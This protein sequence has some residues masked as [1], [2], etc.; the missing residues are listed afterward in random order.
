MNDL[1]F[2]GNYLRSVLDA[3]PSFVFVV[4]EN[5]KILDVNKAAS[6]LIGQNPELIINHIGGDILHCLHSMESN[7]C[8]TSQFCKDCV[9]RNSVEAANSGK[10]IHRKKHKMEIQKNDKK[11][12]IHF[13]VSASP[14]QYNE[15]SLVL[16]IL[17]DITD[18]AELQKIIPI[19]ANCKKIRNDNNY[20][21]QVESF[22][23]K[24]TQLEFSHGICPD[25]FAELYPDMA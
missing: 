19:C 6:Q 16:L 23:R 18:F 12:E 24:Y 25:C 17:E 11:Q 5:V 10:V 8:G 21:E 3:I 14:F 15:S 22:V 1:L 4:D 20:W 9:I 7:G 13:F 2:D